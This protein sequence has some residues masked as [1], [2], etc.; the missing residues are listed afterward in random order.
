MNAIF[1]WRRI[2]L[3]TVFVNGACGRM[4]QAVLKAVQEDPDLALVGAADL[5]GGADVGELV[6]LPKAAIAV[7]TDLKA[8]RG[9]MSCL[10]TSRPRSQRMCRRSSARRA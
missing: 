2:Q 3:T 5:K 7:E 9:P 4:G 1:A 6:G 10:K 8:A